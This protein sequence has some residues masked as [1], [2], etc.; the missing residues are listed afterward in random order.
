MTDSFSATAAS[1]PGDVKSRAAWPSILAIVVLGIFLSF[2]AFR[3]L[4][5]ADDDRL[6]A[7]FRRDAQVRIAAL[8]VAVDHSLDGLTALESL[9]AVEADISR[10]DFAGFAAHYLSAKPVFRAVLWAP[11]VAADARARFEESVRARAGGDPDLE[12][13]QIFE[14]GDEQ[15]VDASPRTA[16]FPILFAEPTAA[17]RHLLGYDVGSWQGTGEAIRRAVDSGSAAATG[18]LGLLPGRAGGYGFM[19]FSPVGSSAERGVEGFL[20][21]MLGVPNLVETALSGLEPA[22]VRI[23]L[24]DLAAPEGLSLL[25]Y[26]LPSPGSAEARAPS[27]ALAS[28]PGRFRVIE[29]L[30]IADRRWLVSAQPGSAYLTSRRTWIPLFGLLGGLLVTVLLAGYFSNIHERMTVARHDAEE[31]LA[32]KRRLED[33][34]EERE[35]AQRELGHVEQSLRHAFDEA[36]IGMAM[37]NLDGGFQ[38]VNRALC[39]TTGY[40]SE[41]LVTMSVAD[42]TAPA[43]REGE[44]L[45][46]TRALEDAAAGGAGA[47]RSYQRI[48]RADGATRWIELDGLV[49]KDPGGRPSYFLGRVQDITERR[50]A[51]EL[52]ERARAMQARVLDSLPISVFLKDEAGRL[53]FVNAST[54]KMLGKSREEVL[55]RTALD[56]FPQSVATGLRKTDIEVMSG[57]RGVQSEEVLEVRG[58]RRHFLV[59]KK[60]IEGG[61]LDRPYLLGFSLDIT[62]AKRARDALRASEYRFRKLVD[63]MRSGVIVFEPVDDGLDFV[64]KDLNRAAERIDDIERGEVLGRR[65]SAALPGTSLNGLPGVF[66]QVWKTGQARR[67]PETRFRDDRH[68]SWR[69]YYV[70]KLPTG[71]IVSICDD[72]TER[73]GLEAKLLHSQRLEAVGRL[74]AGVAHDFNNLLQVISGSAEVLLE[75]LPDAASEAVVARDIHLQTE[76][77]SQLVRRLLTFS[78]GE[79][80]SPERLDLNEVVASAVPLIERFT[81]ENIELAVEL[82]PTSL[83]VIADRRQIEQILMNLAVNSAD[84]MAQGGSLTIRTGGNGAEAW[85]A[86][87]DTGGGVAEE[88]LDKIFDPYFTTKPASQGTG[89]GLAVVHGIVSRHGGRIE[90]ENRPGAGVVISIFLRLEEDSESED[91]TATEE[92]ASAPPR[93]DGERV[94][95]VEDQE[96]VSRVVESMLSRLGYRVTT[97][98]SLALARQSFADDEYELLVSDMLLPDGNGADLAE[99]LRRQRPGLGVL[100]MSGYAEEDLLKKIGQGAF[101]RK[102]FQL[103]DLARA[104]E[105]ALRG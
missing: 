24:Y 25:H 62:E 80:L 27:L 39:A 31:L 41:A 16:Y 71:E 37:V 85:L 76:R 9:Y 81:R 48:V 46:M 90:M 82:D 22:G 52:L 11:R 60:K 84:A 78:R 44:K 7:E 4:R 49:I 88:I 91:E 97:A 29:V 87:E 98:R 83:P 95:V 103:G 54:L 55:G 50:S 93:G 26:H 86:V 43:D 8:R 63:N 58:E 79:S 32:A 13:F 20:V 12:R 3:A 64:V 17:G 15:V 28:E 75:T 104:A 10:S 59:G 67:V 2:L 105:S 53:E 21:V 56:L 92:P 69:E 1:R 65:L 40:S 77:G 42:V 5:R 68:D 47:F 99:E 30:E 102:P 18:R 57:T 34:I 35:R 33:E 73:K 14:E 100:L 6:E 36:P 101:L 51:D 74:A 23:G 89:L 94:L 61:P 38:K 45:A 72:L 96:A 70:Y 66:L 19:V